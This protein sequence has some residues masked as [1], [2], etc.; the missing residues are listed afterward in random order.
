MLQQ[1]LFAEANSKLVDTNLQRTMSN[2]SDMTDNESEFEN[3]SDNDSEFEN[4]SDNASVSSR[5]SGSTDNESISSTGSYNPKADFEVRTLNGIR[6]PE[7]LN[8]PFDA[9]GGKTKNMPLE[10]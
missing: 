9:D 10:H 2:I 4:M 1:Q 5:M 6:D 7:N 8:E 3:I